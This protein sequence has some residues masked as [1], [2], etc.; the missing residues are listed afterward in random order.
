M[1]SNFISAPTQG[2]AQRAR[3]ERRPPVRILNQ[4]TSGTL[5]V[6]WRSCEPR[7]HEEGLR[8]SG[9]T[10]SSNPAGCERVTHLTPAVRSGIAAGVS[11]PPW[12]AESTT[13]QAPPPGRYSTN[14]PPE[15]RVSAMS[16]VPGRGPR[17]AKAPN[18]LYARAVQQ[19]YTQACAAGMRWKLKAGRGRER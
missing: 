2:L 4:N 11:A 13:G 3:V 5:L 16:V 7:S 19:L 10:P 17:Q 18:E 1:A 8:D 15:T 9:F 14:P 12:G 6:L